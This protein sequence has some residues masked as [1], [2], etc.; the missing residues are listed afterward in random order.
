MKLNF[1]P[2]PILSLVTLLFAI[3]KRKIKYFCAIETSIHQIIF[4]TRTR[5][6][7]P[8]SDDK[9]WRQIKIGG[10][11]LVFKRFVSVHGVIRNRNENNTLVQILLKI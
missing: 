11:Q 1:H 2:K 10:I 4:N 9:F 3:Q 6:G 8:R 7:N 5:K